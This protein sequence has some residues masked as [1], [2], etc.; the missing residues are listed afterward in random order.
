M[1]NSF[2]KVIDRQMWVQV[3]PAPNAH[4]AGMGIASD[5][6]ND[7]SRNPFVYSLI[8]ATVLNRFN[9][10][11][12][13]HQFVVSP[14]LGGTFGAGAGCVFA[15]S[16]SLLGNV[17]VGSSTTSLV[18]STTLTAIGINMLAN[19][20]GSGE[21][22]FKIRVIGNSAGGSG[23]IEERWI[24]GNTGGTTPTFY[25]DSALTFTPASGDTYEILGGKVYMLSA[26]VLAATI[27]RS[28]EIATNTIASLSNTN[29]PATI[30]TEFSGIAL[31]E[32]YVPYDAKPGEGF[33]TGDS[34]YD[35]ITKK[36]LL[37]T[38]STVGSITGQATSGD[39]TVIQNEFRN[40]QIRIVED[41]AIPTAVR[42]I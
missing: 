12:K 30:A 8:S 16:M 37:A 13:A 24:V 11:S 2:K 26:G 21:Y 42:T 6:R 17:G 27:F 29:L 33:I 31:D 7:I 35:G 4:A 39:A 38:N 9:I 20:G 10:I 28:F 23:K 32:Q 3:A 36:C 34:T 5:L 1:A 15:P 25:L 41:T 19:R 18:T 14:A 40:F 22:G